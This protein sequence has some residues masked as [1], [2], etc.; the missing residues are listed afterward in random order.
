MSIKNVQKNSSVVAIVMQQ[1]GQKYHSLGPSTERRIEKWCQRYNVNINTI[2][3]A[4]VHQL[5][6]GL[7]KHDVSKCLSVSLVHLWAV[8]K[9]AWKW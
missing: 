9:P 6:V 8:T 7:R 5:L 1:S 4:T 2:S 3:L